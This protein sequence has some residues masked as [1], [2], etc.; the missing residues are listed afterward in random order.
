MTVCLSLNRF[1]NN[2]STHGL[3][4]NWA[5]PYARWRVV[6]WVM[7]LVATRAVGAR[8]TSHIRSNLYAASV[9]DFL[10]TPPLVF[11]T[12]SFA[13]VCAAIFHTVA[14][15]ADELE[16][17]VGRIVTMAILALPAI[18]LALAVPPLCPLHGA[19]SYRLFCGRASSAR[20]SG[21]GGAATRLS[22][23]RQ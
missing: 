7:S 21:G 2:T 14:V 12:A 19:S 1:A 11:H 3:C 23:M 16:G 6:R 13:V 15:D 9:P 17:L 5:A 4:A 8:S 20:S 18:A 22:S 10:R